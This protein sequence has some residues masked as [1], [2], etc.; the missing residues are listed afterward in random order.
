MWRLWVIYVCT[1]RL[2]I[3]SFDVFHWN[4][5]TNGFPTP[6]NEFF[7]LLGRGIQDSKSGDF[8]FENRILGSQVV[9][10]D[11]IHVGICL[12]EGAFFFFYM[13]CNT[14]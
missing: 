9:I 1:L 2:F 4:Y 3:Q 13:V 10:S 6:K 11:V 8:R 12:L 7:T 14:E 5:K